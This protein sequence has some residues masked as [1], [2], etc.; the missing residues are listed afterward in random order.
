MPPGETSWIGPSQSIDYGG[1]KLE[2]VNINL[3]TLHHRSSRNARFLIGGSLGNNAKWKGRVEKEEPN[4]IR[5][6][7]GD[8]F[9]SNDGGKELN[10]L[11]RKRDRCMALGPPI[12][13]KWDGTLGTRVP[14]CIID[15]I[16]RD[17]AQLSRQ[18]RWL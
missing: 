9:R 16:C 1:V 12:H 15:E 7:A 6:E 11:Q 5:R 4:G 2:G 17:T 13:R 3:W 14:R 18:M 10:N 8:Y